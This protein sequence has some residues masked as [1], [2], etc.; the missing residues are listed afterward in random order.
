MKEIEVKITPVNL[1]GFIVKTYDKTSDL[2]SPLETRVAKNIK[3]LI[4]LLKQIYV[5]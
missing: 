3:D 1:G 4:K 5:E 2:R